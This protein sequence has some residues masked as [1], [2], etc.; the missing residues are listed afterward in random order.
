MQKPP[1][2]L[3]N[4]TSSSPLNQQQQ[5]PSSA[6]NPYINVNY[7][8]NIA[9]N[10]NRYSDIQM[11]IIPSNSTSSSYINPNSYNSSINM[12][13]S[14]SYSNQ[15]PRPASTPLVSQSAPKFQLLYHVQPQLQQ[16]QQKV[17]IQS[18]NSNMNSNVQQLSNAAQPTMPTQQA[19]PSYQS[20]YLIASPVGSQPTQSSYSTSMNLKPTSKT[21]QPYTNFVSTFFAKVKSKSLHFVGTLKQIY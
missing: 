7:S 3:V 13:Q 20:H 9:N 5:Q 10:P 2:Y 6:I 16:F 11:T 17:L 14:T 12:N 4:H 21:L 18:L 8:S 1:M 19:Q 15:Q